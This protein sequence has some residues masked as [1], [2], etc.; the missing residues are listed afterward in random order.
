MAGLKFAEKL[1]LEVLEALP[2]SE[3]T[4]E[5]RDRAGLLASIDEDWQQELR[6]MND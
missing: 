4:P 1:E 3:R 2:Y 6:E 5:Q